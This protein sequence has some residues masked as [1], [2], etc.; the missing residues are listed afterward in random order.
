MAIYILKTNLILILLYGF[1]RLMMKQDTFFNYR[2]FILLALIAVSIFVPFLNL[3]VLFQGN[4]TAESM[5]GT[6]ASFITPVVSVY[7]SSAALT[8]KDV[9]S[10]IYLLGVAILTIRFL[11]QLVSIFSLVRHTSSQ[12]VEGVPV[13]ILPEEQS[14]FSFMQWIFVNP[15]AQ[16]VEQLHEIMVHEQTHARQWHSVDILFSEMFCIFC[17]FNP[18]S[19]L[20]KREIRLNLEYLADESVLDRGTTRKSYQY[21]LLGLAYHPAKDSLT[22]Q[23]NVLQLKNRIKMMN[24]HRTK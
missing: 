5:A 16:S 10:G 7:A 15:D 13:H 3:T 1:Y 11:W 21:H 6:Y 22:N 24:K 2:R 9:A 20:M 19:W 8:W 23:F 17:W 18:F 4:T 14:P 12:E